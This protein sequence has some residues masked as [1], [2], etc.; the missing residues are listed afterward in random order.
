MKTP[1]QRFHCSYL[2]RNDGCWIWIKA[3]KKSGYGQFAFN[4]KIRMYAHRA[5]YKLLVGGIPKGLCV[6]HK[7]D[8][9]NCVNPEHLF[10]G[11]QKENIQDM[12]KKGRRHDRHEAGVKLTW[13]KVEKIRKSDKSQLK[14]A[15]EYG[16]SQP[17]I[18]HIK[19]FRTWNVPE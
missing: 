16:V 2:V 9:R 6:L 10:L 3:I 12:V 14:L 8:V 18:S 13:D 11:T 19:N 5:S 4:S 1:L 7:C 15:A 17:T